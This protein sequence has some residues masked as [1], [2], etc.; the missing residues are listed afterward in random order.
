VT[1][2]ELRGR[3]ETNESTQSVVELR[4]PIPQLVV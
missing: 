3:N 2:W 1:W 4:R